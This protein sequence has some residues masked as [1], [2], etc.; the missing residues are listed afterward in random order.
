MYWSS[1]CIYIYWPVLISIGPFLFV[2]SIITSFV[3]KWELLKCLRWTHLSITIDISIKNSSVCLF[4]NWNIYLFF[5]SISEQMLNYKV[6][7]ILIVL[8]FATLLSVVLIYLLSQWGLANISFLECGY[9]VQRNI[10]ANMFVWITRDLY[11]LSQQREPANSISRTGR[12]RPNS[13]R[14]PSLTWPI[15]SLS[16]SF[17]YS[18][19]FCTKLLP[20][21]KPFQSY[22]RVGRMKLCWL[23]FDSPDKRIKQLFF[24]SLF[25]SCLCGRYPAFS[26]FVIYLFSKDF[27][28]S[29]MPA[30]VPLQIHSCR[31]FHSGNPSSE[32]GHLHRYP[33]QKLLICMSYLKNILPLYLRINHNFKKHQETCEQVAD[34]LLFVKE[35]GGWLSI[36]KKFEFCNKW[37]IFN[38]LKWNS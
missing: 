37:H 25:P 20:C 21:D 29:D 12:S 6:R 9:P 27:W 8:L 11:A 28:C 38:V 17:S 34:K 3:Q 23:M 16:C 31:V 10:F 4:V 18:H 14:Q 1:A 13:Y 36:L 33:E 7:S 15:P 32:R 19:S 24:F 2:L 30:R 35:Q 26:R 5:T 22:M